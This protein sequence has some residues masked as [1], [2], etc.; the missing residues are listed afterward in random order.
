MFRFFQPIVAP[1]VSTLDEDSVRFF[2]FENCTNYLDLLCSRR[3]KPLEPTRCIK[4]E[5]KGTGVHVSSLAVKA[6]SER[7]GG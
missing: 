2:F 5:K 3:D 4:K 1:A 6:K 7:D